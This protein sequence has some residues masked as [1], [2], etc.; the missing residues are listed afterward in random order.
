[1]L[2]KEILQKYDGDLILYYGG[3]CREGY[4]L[5]SDILENI[6]TKKSKVCLVLVTYGGD[7]DAG[8]RIARALNHHF[9]NVKF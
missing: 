4:Q 2:T 3:I 1:M 8:Y 5:V 6:E 7:P 9:E